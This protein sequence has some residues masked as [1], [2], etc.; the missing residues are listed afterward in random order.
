MYMREEFPCRRAR[1]E[2]EDSESRRG[3]GEA[4]GKKAARGAA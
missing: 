4:T 3:G 2:D 1:F